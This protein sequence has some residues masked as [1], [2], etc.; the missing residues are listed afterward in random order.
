MYGQLRLFDYSQVV[1]V[2]TELARLL[3]VD[4]DVAVDL[5]L[6]NFH[7]VGE[8]SR[9]EEHDSFADLSERAVLADLAEA[10]DKRN[11][12]PGLLLD[13]ADSGLLLG[14]AF[15]DVTL[16]KAPVPSVV[17]LDEEDFCVLP[18]LVEDN[19]AA[20]FLVKTAD[21]LQPDVAQLRKYPS[22][23]WLSERSN[24]GT[25]SRLHRLFH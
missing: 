12:K 16:G 21:R 23:C 7:V 9:E 11:V 8:G 2:G 24:H 22:L 14:F 4:P 15:L 10:V 5:L 1:V 3:Q 25:S 19:A 17:V 13:L 20:G 6:L 18:R